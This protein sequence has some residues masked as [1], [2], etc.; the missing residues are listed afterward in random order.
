MLR[1]DFREAWSCM[2]VLNPWRAKRKYVPPPQSAYQR[3]KDCA[4]ARL[5]GAYAVSAL[6]VCCIVVYCVFRARAIQTIETTDPHARADRQRDGHIVRAFERAVESIISDQ[7]PPQQ[8]AYRNLH[9]KRHFR[10]FS[11]YFHAKGMQN[12]A[13]NESDERNTS[14]ADISDEARGAHGISAAR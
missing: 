3:L 14:S 13:W 4:V 8:T 2:K 11:H 9:P 6:A 7:P 10:N 5:L 12:L 1:K